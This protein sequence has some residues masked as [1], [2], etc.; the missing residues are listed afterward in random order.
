MAVPIAVAASVARA[1]SLSDVRS[2]SFSASMANASFQYSS[3]KPS[4]SPN[5]SFPAG[6]SPKEKTAITTIGISM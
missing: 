4:L 3:V 6:V 1:A 2:D 5:V